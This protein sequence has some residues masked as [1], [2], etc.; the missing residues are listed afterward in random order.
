MHYEVYVDSLF[1]VNFVMNLYLLLLVDR[2]SLGTA[3]PGRLLSGAALGGICCLLPLP[4]MAPAAVKLALGA[5]VGTVGMLLV[6]FPVKS[7]RMFLKLLEK[8]LLYSFCMGG[9]LLFLIRSFPALRGFLGKGSGIMGVGGV[10]YLF[11]VHSRKKDVQA[12]WMCRAILVR[13]ESIVTVEAMVDTGNSLMEPISGKPVCVV[14]REVLEKLGYVGSG[15]RHEG[16]LG[17]RVIPYHSIGKKRG[18]LEGYL[19][20]HLQIQRDGIRKD[21]QD[22]YIAAGPEGIHGAHSAGTESIKMIVNPMLLTEEKGAARRQNA[23]RYDIKSGDTRKTTVQN[24][25]Q[26]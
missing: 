5:V 24:D 9:G 2:S 16:N 4:F 7:F 8:L 1:L 26:G 11:L 17:Y 20:P 22:V 23:R 25:P 3:T 6:A 15:I 19:L 13:G 18:I 14:D 10:L 21:F 12:D